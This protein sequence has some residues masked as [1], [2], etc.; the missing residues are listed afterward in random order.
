MTSKR[1]PQPTMVI[2]GSPKSHG[3]YD[4]GFGELYPIFSFSGAV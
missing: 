3:L 4:E 2:M 1:L